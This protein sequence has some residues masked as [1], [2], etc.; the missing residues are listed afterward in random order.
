LFKE[1][2][3]STRE[4][5]G[6]RFKP[7]SNKV[8]RIFSDL[9]GISFDCEKIGVTK[10]QKNKLNKKREVFIKRAIL[11]DSNSKKKFS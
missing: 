2:S 11:N 8:D 7:L 4:I 6:A 5:S 9:I 1:E 3:S 10:T